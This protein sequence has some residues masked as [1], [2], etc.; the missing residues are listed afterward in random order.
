MESVTSLDENLVSF[1]GYTYR[2]AESD[3]R[4]L[5]RGDYPNGNT[6]YSKRQHRYVLSYIPVTGEHMIL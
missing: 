4:A 2:Y 3:G 6:S 1:K 5:Q